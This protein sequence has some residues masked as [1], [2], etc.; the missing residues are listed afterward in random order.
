MVKLIRYLSVFY[1][2]HDQHSDCVP[3]PHAMRVSIE[4]AMPIRMT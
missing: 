4:K 3:K 1:I 2:M